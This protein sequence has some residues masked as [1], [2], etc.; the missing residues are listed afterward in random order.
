MVQQRS[1]WP[2][3]EG[4]LCRNNKTNQSD[5]A[6]L[7]FLY[8]FVNKKQRGQRTSVAQERLSFPWRTTKH[9]TR[10]RTSTR[11]RLSLCLYVQKQYK[12]HAWLPTA[13]TTCARK[14]R[15]GGSQLGKLALQEQ[16]SVAARKQQRVLWQETIFQLFEFLL[17]LGERR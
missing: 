10:G 14:Q 16:R 11:P 12:K 5:F 6:F 2:W 3:L 1:L 4:S 9:P 7:C 13:N 8:D 15:T 17:M